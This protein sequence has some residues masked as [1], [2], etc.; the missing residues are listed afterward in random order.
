M[1]PR[2]QSKFKKYASLFI[3]MKIWIIFFSPKFIFCW[4]DKKN[5]FLKLAYLVPMFGCELVY[6]K[7]FNSFHWPDKFMCLNVPAYVKPGLLEFQ[8][9]TMTVWKVCS[10]PAKINICHQKTIWGRPVTTLI[11][12]GWYLGGTGNVNNWLIPQ[13]LALVPGRPL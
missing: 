11:R 13:W 2:N 7:A 5:I 4:H 12:W 6:L 8:K 1:S 3:N 9:K 10:R